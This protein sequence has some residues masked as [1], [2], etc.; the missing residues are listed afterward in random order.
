MHDG[1]IYFVSQIKLVIFLNSVYTNNFTFDVS[2]GLFHFIREYEWY[3][4]LQMLKKVADVVTT[5]SKELTLQSIVVSVCT[6]CL[7]I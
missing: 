6:T 4:E 2:V 1:V 7:N 5:A 3:V